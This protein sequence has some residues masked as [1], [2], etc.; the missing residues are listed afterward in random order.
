MP[1]ALGFAR[2]RARCPEAAGCRPHRLS[3][4]AVC[5]ALL[6]RCVLLYAAL[7][8]FA[9]VAR[10]LTALLTEHL[11]DRGHPRALQ[12]SVPATRPL[13][14][15]GAGRPVGHCSCSQPLGNTVFANRKHERVCPW[16]SRSGE[17]L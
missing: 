9:D 11:A 13:P 12:V 8:S 4:L 3:C 17:G 15:R 10:P 1:A 2:I 6:Q 5:L 14:R 16:H 7:P